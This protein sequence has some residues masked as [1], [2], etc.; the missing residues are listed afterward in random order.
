MTTEHSH[1]THC[2]H[3]HHDHHHESGCGCCGHHHHGAY[4]VDHGLTVQFSGEFEATIDAVWQMLTDNTQVQRW[5]PELKFE[6][7]EPGGT[8]RFNYQDG[9]SEEMMILDVEAP[10]YLSFTWDINIVTF[11]LT[12]T[13]SGNTVLIFTEWLAQVNDHSPK[14]LTGW[15]ICLQNIAALLEGKELE[16]REEKFHELYPRIKE[17]LEQQT[18]MEFED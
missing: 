15:M 14:D 2:C 16:D 17:M 12:A 9:G 8:L 3:N 1:E 10:H 18:N 4:D 13:E 7:L 11:E 6:D 5:F